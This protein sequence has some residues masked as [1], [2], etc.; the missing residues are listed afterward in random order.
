MEVLSY[1]CP[2]CDA[3][4]KYD[5]KAKKMH[6]EYCDSTFEAEEVKAFNDKRAKEA[7]ED[8]EEQAA[9]EKAEEFSSDAGS[10]DEEDK[11]HIASFTCSTC[12]GELI[13]DENTVASSC[14][15]CGNP[16][17]VKHRLEGELKP[18]LVLPFCVTKEEAKAALEKFCKKKLLL[19]KFFSSESRLESIRG[20]YLPFWLYSGNAEADATYS[21]TRVFT[22]TTPK[23]N[24]VRTD[25]YSLERKGT[26]DFSDLAVDGATFMDDALMDSLEPFDFGKAEEFT[27]AYLAGYMA[28]K[29]DLTHEQCKERAVSRLRGSADKLLSSTVRGFATSVKTGGNMRLLKTEARYALLP[30]WL[31]VTEYKGKKYTFAMNGQTG[32]F[33]GTLPISEKKFWLYLLLFGLGASLVFFL[34]SLLLV[35]GG[36]I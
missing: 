8:A 17:M 24:I 25:H 31:L 13:F 20:I 22:T 35:Y 23:Y 10:W 1:K 36:V 21:A 3:A 12:G 28:N 30:A 26:I 7:E 33:V 16:A 32:R 15:Y 34:I 4:L 27:S 19:P 18:A 6:C 29:Y 2:C 11:E 9:E 5:G 14:P